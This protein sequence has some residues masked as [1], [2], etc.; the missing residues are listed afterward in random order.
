MWLTAKYIQLP[1]S[2][3]RI[4]KYL[5]DND[6][7]HNIKEIN[8]ENTLVLLYNQLKLKHKAVASPSQLTGHY[9]D[10]NKT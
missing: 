10:P 1:L 9:P 8:H 6:V 7:K 5:N 2:P 3:Y 4:A